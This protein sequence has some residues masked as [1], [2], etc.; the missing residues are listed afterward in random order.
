METIASSILQYLNHL[1]DR[2]YLALVANSTSATQLCRVI[3]ELLQS[4]DDEVVSSACL[5]IRDLVVLGS[6]HPGCEKFVQGYAESSIVTTLEQLIFSPNHFTRKQAIYT[7]GKTCSDGSAAAL[8]QA[9][10]VFRDTDPILL[11]RLIGEIGWLGAETFWALLA[12][13]IDS[14]VY[15]TRWAVI[16]VLDEFGGDNAQTQDELFQYK[17]KCMKQLRQD[18]NSLVQAEA[19]YK[20]QL[21][22]LRSEAYDLPKADYRKQRKNLKRE[23]EPALCFTY[24]SSAFLYHLCANNLR[25]YSIDELELFIASMA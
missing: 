10:W 23:Y 3:N 21:L 14:S 22:K 7:L 15:A 13:M 2:D 19:E 8:T 18:S 4:E 12:S 5:F 25:Q 6:Q 24:V 20:Y 17:F 16:A 1:Q 9:F 11:P